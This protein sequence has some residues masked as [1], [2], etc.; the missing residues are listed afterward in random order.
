MLRN[1]K[2]LLFNFIAMLVIIALDVL[3]LTVGLDKQYIFKTMPSVFFVVVGI[4][5]LSFAYRMGID[6]K[7]NKIFAILMLIGL[8]FAMAGDIFLIDYF[9]LGAGLFAV[10]HVFFFIAYLQLS[11]FNIR[12]IICYVILLIP[13]MLL[14]L[15]YDGFT[16][17]GIMLPV[18]IIYAVI[19]SLM[20]GKSISNLFNKEM[21][22]LAKWIIFIGS[23]MFFIS[24]MWL[25]FNVF[26][27]WG[28]WTD[29][30]CLAFYYPAEIILAASIFYATR[31][32]KE[33][34]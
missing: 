3:Y 20:L 27:H 6:S 13:V 17:D 12:D 7:K 9:I 8:I 11:K 33:E 24:D 34:N 1:K 23:V 4:L 5:N 28:F 29:V 14:I 18:V 32:Y 15:L 2:V 16:F 10:G 31:E 21:N 25:L 26:G 22:K 19:I 30:L